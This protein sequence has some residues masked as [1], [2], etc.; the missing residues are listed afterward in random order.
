[1]K[2]PSNH[3]I[4]AVVLAVLIAF[5]LVYLEVQTRP[6]KTLVRGTDSDWERA[7]KYY[8][9]TIIIDTILL[10]GNELHRIKVYVN[11]PIQV[12]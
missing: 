10:D 2:R 4:S 5:L 8:P 6:F 7:E 3:T 11:P 9:D 12:N 1:M